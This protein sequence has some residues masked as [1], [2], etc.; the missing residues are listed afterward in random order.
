MSHRTV[1]NDWRDALA[2]LIIGITLS[3]YLVK[4]S[5]AAGGVGRLLQ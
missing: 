1:T 2:W 3:W 5:G 4:M